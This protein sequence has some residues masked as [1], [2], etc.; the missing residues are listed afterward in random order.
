[1][2]HFKCNS[3]HI[4]FL[5]MVCGLLFS[6]RNPQPEAS[7]LLARAIT[8]VDE[9][10]DSALRLIDSIF[11]PEESLNK[12]AY[13]RYLVTQVQARYKNYLPIQEDTLIFIAKDYFTEH[14]KNL[15]QTALAYFY[16]GC[17]YREQQNYKE[18]MQLYKQAKEFAAQYKDQNLEGLIMFNIGDLLSE[19]GLYSEALKKYK[20]AEN[21]YAKL[22]SNM[23][24][25]RITC[26]SAIGK[27]YL[28]M[29]EP[30]SASATFEE[31]LK[32][33]T[34][35]QNKELQSLL[36]QNLSVT[37]LQEREYEKAEEYLRRSF[38]LES[39]SITYPRFYLN[40]AL[41]YTQVGLKDS[42]SLYTKKLKTTLNELEDNSL[43]VSIYRYLSEKEKADGNFNAAFDY[44]Y[45]YIDEIEKI[46]QSQLQQSVY[47]IQQKYDFE[48]ANKKHNL[49]LLVYKNWIIALLL[50][51]FAVG[52]FYVWYAIRQKNKLLKM[53]QTL[54]TWR[55]MA[56]KEK[57]LRETN[58]KETANRL[59]EKMHELT[60]LQVNFQ[61]QENE[62][63]Q[64]RQEQKLLHERL[65]QTGTKESKEEIL[66]K[67]EE[68][69]TL[70]TLNTAKKNNALREALIWQLGVVSK[71]SR[72]DKMEKEL[73][74][75]LLLKEFKRVV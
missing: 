18:A 71:V 3:L 21:F 17:V 47:E 49:Q 5:T 62:L 64:V 1:M 41:L 11:Y 26:L 34:S 50:M 27:T 40:F 60:L 39:D 66:N 10:P 65:T 74:P 51:L 48:L 15:Q 68:L 19:Q 22:P 20:R 73:S 30:D 9:N 44:Q 6:C 45:K 52:S 33:S 56:N 32:L 61:K 14:N 29:E 38:D 12:E 69:N 63:Q 53:Y 75:A 37:Y 72:L 31:G 28:L 57:Q 67:L 7:Q 43:K 8:L 70:Y 59:S 2:K 46:T 24:K 42:A 16:S 25:K 13:M 58:D 54:Q 36:A 55:E 4:V 23:L 35:I